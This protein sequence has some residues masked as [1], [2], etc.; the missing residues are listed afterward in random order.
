MIDTVRWEEMLPA[1]FVARRDAMPLC[2]VAF[3]LAEPH[4]AYNALGLD[5]LKAR[6]LVERTASAHGGIVAPPMA[7]HVQDR[8]E[9]HDNG[10]GQGWFHAVGIT[11]SLASSLPFD[12]FLQMA[13]FQIRAIDA[14][15]FHAAVLVTG[16]NGGIDGLIAKLC[17]YYIRR[18]GSPIRLDALFDGKCLDPAMPYRGD[19]AG[20]TETSQL[21]AL[22]P[23]MVDLDQPPVPAELGTRFA[24]GI[25]PQK[26]PRPSR[27]IGERIV[28]AQVE[29]LGERSKQ[30][31]AG[32]APRAGWRAPTIN[33]ASDIWH[34][35][36]RLT[37]PYWTVTWA[38]YSEGGRAQ[39]FPSWEALG[40]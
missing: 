31:M 3:G 7:W 13:L 36:A 12:L 27:E 39:P 38:T 20:M 5:F 22:C 29:R 6:G 15:G 2:Y 32:Y 37:R 16:H 21:M 8:P 17:D 19:H 4:G 24:A 9:F 26:E 11:R 1:Q 10:H 14:A 33:D 28:A 40:E 35:F 23:G 25:D 18:T 30:L 34:R